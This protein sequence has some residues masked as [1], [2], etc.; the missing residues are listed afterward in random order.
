MPTGTTVNGAAFGQSYGGSFGLGEPRHRRRRNPRS[1]RPARIHQLGLGHFDR[2][3]AIHLQSH[4]HRRA[5]PGRDRAGALPGGLTFT[6]NG[7]G[8]ATIAGTRPRAAGA[9]IPSPSARPMCPGTISQ[10]F[11]LTNAEAPTITSPAT[12]AFVTGVAGTYNVTTTGFPAATITESRCA[13]GRASPS[14]QRQRHRHHLRHGHNGGHLSRQPLRHQ[15]VGQHFDAGAHPHGRRPGGSG[16]HQPPPPPTSP[17]A[18]QAPLPFTTTGALS[19]PALTET[20]P[21]ARRPDP[22]RTRSNGIA[23]RYR[24]RP[25]PPGP[26]T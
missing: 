25:P 26:P 1:A 13:A 5:Q 16:D 14:P 4:H 24:G 9:A 10:A 23:L 18:R 3:C 12:A 20:G 7:D 21:A 2:G 15:R 6:D 19:A 11:T 8:T 17:S 22:L